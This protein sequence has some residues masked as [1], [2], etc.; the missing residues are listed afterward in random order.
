MDFTD[1]L[2]LFVTFTAGAAALGAAYLLFPATQ[3][4]WKKMR[5]MFR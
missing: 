3:G 5:G 1:I 4:A 2:A